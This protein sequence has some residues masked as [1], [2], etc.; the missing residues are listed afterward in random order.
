MNT[1]I[2]TLVLAATLAVP[3]AALAKESGERKEKNKTYREE[4]QTENKAFRETLK[5]M[6]EEQRKAAIIDHR[7][8]QFSENV[9]RHE[10]MHQERIKFRC[11][12][13]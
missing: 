9:A 12:H 13:L 7:N 4:Q 1:K 10:K 6:P 3:M 11:R 5:D 2:L 8:S